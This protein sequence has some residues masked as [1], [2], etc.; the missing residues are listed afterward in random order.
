MVL[1][2]SNLAISWKTQLFSTCFHGVTGILLLVA[3]WQPG[4]SMIW[5]PLLVVLVASW[6]KSQKNISKVKGVA[7]L[8]NGNKFQWKKN[9]WEIVKT[10]WCSRFGILLTLNALQGKPR[11]LRLWI[12]K[13]ALSEENWR[14]LNQLLLQYPDI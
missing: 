12:A 6:A 7:V 14:N 2:K 9:E 1:W 11:K 5:L 3:P 10:P 13:D 8:V 4:N